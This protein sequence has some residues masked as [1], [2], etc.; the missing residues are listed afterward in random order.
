M[1]LD[2]DFVR[3]Q[4]PQLRD[5]PGLVFCANAGGSYVARQVLEQLQ[6]YD[7]HTRVQPYSNFAPSR[8]AGEAMDRARR[9]WCQALN[10]DDAELTLGPS[11]SIN[12]Y[13]MAQ[14]L[15]EHW[16][17]GDEIVVT[18]QDHEANHGV[19]RRKAEQRGATVR[20]WAVDPDSGLLDPQDLYAML[21]EHTRWVFFSHCSNVMGT[22]NPV[23]GI[24]AGIRERCKARVCVD[25]VAFAPHY[26]SDLRALDVDMYLFSMYKVFGP[27]QGLLYVRAPVAESLEPQCHFFNRHYVDK[28]FNPAGPQHGLQAACAGVVDYFDALYQHHFSDERAS[29]R[30]RIDAVHELT[31]AHEEALCAPLLDYLHASPRVRLLGKSHCRDGDRAATIAWTP[32]QQTPA[33][34]AAALQSLGIGTESGHFYAHR[35]IASVNLDPA[36]GV[37]RFSLLHYNSAG[38]VERILAALDR[39]LAA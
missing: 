23:A 14:A 30:Q 5:D 25:A 27:H 24:I 34:A 3:Q 9:V 13:V 1:Q 18:Q 2:L 36:Q 28:R 11:T 29:I 22:V 6:H 17:P 19:W 21:N 37:V 12:S 35:A 39:V 16:V 10:I 7:S 26:L 33:A 15:G 4:F 31:A 38:D 8:D 32:L 20:E